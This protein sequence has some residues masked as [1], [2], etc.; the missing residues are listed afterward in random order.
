MTG[1]NAMRIALAACA[2]IQA[3]GWATLASAQTEP[4]AA[5]AGADQPAEANDAEIIVTA[6]RRSE[7][8][9][10]VPV[11]VTALAGD[12]LQRLGIQ[13]TKDLTRITPGLNFTQSVYS[14]QP[15]I[16]GIG[17]RGVGAGDESVVPIYIDGVYQ[18]F[19]AAADLQFNNVE[20]IEVLK[21]PQ[22]ALLGRNATAGAINIITRTP[23]LEPSG[24]V[25]LSYGRFDQ[26][27]TRA[28]GSVGSGPISGSV[29]FVA[30]YDKGYIND[31]VSGRRY[32]DTQEI[33]GRARLRVVASDNLEFNFSVAK[34]RSKASTGEAYRPLNRDTIGARIPGNVYGIK[35][36]TSALS[37]DPF[38]NLRSTTGSAS[39]LLHLGGFDVTSVLGLQHNRVAVLADSD[40]SVADL[41]SIGFEQVGD[42]LYHETYLTSTF[43][44]PI[45]LIG[46]VVYYHSHD[47][48]QNLST[49][50]RAVSPAGVLGARSVTTANADGHTDSYAGYLQAT[51]KFSDAWS[52][53][54]GGRYTT[55]KRD[56]RVVAST[57]TFINK[58]TFRKF[59]P[60]ATLQFTPTRH[61]NIY[62]KYGE[63]FKTGIFNLSA[64][65]AVALTP[66]RPENVK[67]YEVGLKA[68]IAGNLQ[69][70]LAAF[71]TDYKNLQSPARN[72]IGQSYLQNAGA[73]KIY[74]GEAELIW[75]AAPQLNFR[76]SAALLHGTYR[77]FPNSQVSI[78]ATTGDAAAPAACVRNPGTLIG[79]NRT[80]IC[81]V[82]GNDIIRAPFVQL[83]GSAD[84]T[85]PVGDGEVR[86][87]A[88]A[89]YSGHSYWD[90]LNYFREP[91]YVLVG[92]ELSWRPDASP[93]RITAW[94]DN[95][96]NEKYSLTVTASGTATSQVLARPRTYGVRL[97]YDF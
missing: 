68:G 27:Q 91:S 79:G 14:P 67:Q 40:G 73:A 47:Q 5:S 70:N 60:T 65:S 12:Q 87:A 83:S 71:Y 49:I 41:A 95:L 93:L 59:T 31:I 37:F 62:A 80:F 17:L 69:V 58:A 75:R 76:A 85:V 9:Q 21:G 13:G 82:S 94:G 84:Y 3:V 64:S 46:G 4:A 45:S 90:T 86:L 72:A 20:R 25:S 36:Y 19:T 97:N 63:A 26:I 96:L 8:L 89:Y 35:P 38:N 42:S 78:P 34:K 88:N 15:T 52:I 43:D 1:K 54:G 61:L 7:R 28:Y 44:G 24:A 77:D 22:G 53:T 55:E 66:V 57:G 18:P 81:D 2:G 51:W 6:Q 39:A 33:S 56:A 23:T 50:A 32:G 10:D 48:N 29:A 74:G 16:R 92:G 30:N 11:A